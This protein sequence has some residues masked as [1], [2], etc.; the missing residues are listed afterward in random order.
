MKFHNVAFGMLMLGLLTACGDGGPKYAR[1]YAGIQTVPAKEEVNNSPYTVVSKSDLEKWDYSDVKPVE[2]KLTKSIAVRA[3][4]V[5]GV[6]SHNVDDGFVVTIPEYP[7]FTH[8][9]SRINPGAMPLITRLAA[10][11][12]KDPSVRLDIISHYHYDGNNHKALAESQKRAVAIQAG[13]MSR[14]VGLERTRAVGAGDQNPVAQNGNPI[15][16]QKNRRIE[17]H[18]KR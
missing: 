14:G 9:S 18:F 10:A 4:N 8:P 12:L 17:L 6:T 3:L 16:E 11:M 2:Q 15:N 13:L 5:N 1:G 7:F